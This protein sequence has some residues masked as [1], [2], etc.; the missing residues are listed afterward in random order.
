MKRLTIIGL[1][2][3]IFGGL[4]Y[5]FATGEISGLSQALIIGLVIGSALALKSQLSKK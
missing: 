3:L 2:I 5:P 4:I 1:L